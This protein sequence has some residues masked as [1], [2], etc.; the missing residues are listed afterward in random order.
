MTSR[1]AVQGMTSMT[2][3]PS[4]F[5]ELPLFRAAFAQLK[6]LRWLMVEMLFPELLPASASVAR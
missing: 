3:L 1:P 4:A 6:K 5:P 2:L